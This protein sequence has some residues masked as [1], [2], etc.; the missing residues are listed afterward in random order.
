MAVQTLRASQDLDQFRDTFLGRLRALAAAHTLLSDGK[1]AAAPIAEVVA[2]TL[3]PF[4]VDGRIRTS[5]D[6][7][8]LAGSAVTD[9]TMCLHELATNAVKYGALST[10]AGV[11]T[12]QWRRLGPHRAR[13]DWREDGGPP[14]RPPAR[15]GLG[16]RLLERGLVPGEP[17]T[18]EYR[19]GGVAWSSLAPV[20]EEPPGAASRAPG[21]P[22]AQ[23]L[24][25]PPLSEPPLPMSSGT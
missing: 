20:L 9:L 24:S 12:V 1:G 8:R 5:G 6:P 15:R 4:R 10:P 11:V 2:R 19:E 16:T 7:L 25:E 13:I 22:A 14:V 3:G 18:L 17:P 23:P 21:A